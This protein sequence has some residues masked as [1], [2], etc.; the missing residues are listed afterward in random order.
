MA[1]KQDPRDIRTRKLIM[2]SFMQLVIEYDFKDITI[3]DITERATIN[4]ATF[5]YHFFDK[6]DLLEAVISEDIL[7]GVLN[8]VNSQQS[9]DIDRIKEVLLNLIRF[10]QGLKNQC[11]R[12]YEAFT[13]KIETIV[14]E[15]LEVV[16][17]DIL[18]K[19]RSDFSNEQ[20]TLE[21]ITLSWGLYG[22]SS[23]YVLSGKT[24]DNEVISQAIKNLIPK[25]I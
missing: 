24:P 13:P 6:Y 25:N 19:E 10:H 23:F 3:K 9:L 12:S 20:I 16:F 8:E 14:K 11:T 15:Q 21:A 5:Y 17:K 22:I 7:K 1:K 4:R 2:S 18:K